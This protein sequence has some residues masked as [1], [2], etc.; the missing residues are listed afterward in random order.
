MRAH[1][2]EQP[3][4]DRGPDRASLQRARRPV[5]ALAALGPT[6]ARRRAGPCPRP[7]PRRAGRRPSCAPASTIVTGRGFQARRPLAAAEVARDLLERALGRREADALER[8]ARQLLAAA[9]A[10]ARGARRACVPT[11]AW[12]SSTITVST[13]A[14]DR[15]RPRGEQQEERLGRRDQDVGRPARPSRAR[16]AGGVSPVR[17]P[18]SRQ[19]DASPRR[20]ATRAMPASGVAQVAL[21]VHRQRLERRDVDDAAAL[22]LR[23]APG[24]NIS[25]SIAA[26]NA[27]SVLPEPVGAK[28]SALSPPAI[29][30]P[31]E[32]LRP[33][34]RARRSRRTTPAPPGA[35]GSSVGRRSSGHH[36]RARA[37][38]RFSGCAA[39][40]LRVGRHRRELPRLLLDLLQRDLDRPLELQVLARHRPRPGR[41]RLTHVGVGA[42][43]LDQP[44]AVARRR[45]RCSTARRVPLSIVRW[46]LRCRRARPTTARRPRCRAC[47]P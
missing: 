1:E 34:R 42:V 41:C 31:A 20:P 7:A 23:R 2:L 32:P 38:G 30:G 36:R 17:T 8:P 33:R 19:V 47:A 14:E 44:L 3:R 10:R 18:T 46:P 11:S 4:V 37:P 43:V 16:S 24:A 15:A 13:D 28:T 22:G 26:R 6:G 5:G 21:D 29:A 45:R 12:I 35:N 9:R 39:S 27:A 40:V 25:R